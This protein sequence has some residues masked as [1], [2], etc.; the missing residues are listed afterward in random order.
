MEFYESKS[1]K[2]APDYSLRTTEEIL[3]FPAKIKYKEAEEV[4]KRML[5]FTEARLRGIQNLREL[6]Q[7]E[8]IN[9]FVD[10]NVRQQILL[11][12]MR[13]FYKSV[14][15][16]RNDIV[17]NVIANFRKTEE[18]IRDGIKISTIFAESNPNDRRQTLLRPS[19]KTVLNYEFIITPSFLRNFGAEYRQA[20]RTL[21]L[22]A[23]W[24]DLRR[25]YFR[26]DLHWVLS[27]KSNTVDYLHL[28]N[29][30]A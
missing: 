17:R 20:P 15:T 12:L 21:Q 2:E 24:Y 28:I 3:S 8:D 5:T 16:V 22:L 19:V 4:R 25:K 11:I 7:Y 14:P 23:E 10:D 30:S 13:D 18:V 27:A 29:D 6:A 9:C 1:I 26:D